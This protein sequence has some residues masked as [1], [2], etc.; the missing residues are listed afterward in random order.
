VL[1]PAGTDLEIALP[2]MARSSRVAG[3]LKEALPCDPAVP[4]MR[5]PGSEVE[6]G[7]AY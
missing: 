6:P 7:P 3:V 2:S 4:V 5:T 1:R